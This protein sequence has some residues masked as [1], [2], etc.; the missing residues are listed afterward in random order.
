MKPN[1]CKSGILVLFLLVFFQG[2]RAQKTDFY[3]P[4]GNI[5]RKALELYRQGNY[6]AAGK[7]F[8]RYENRLPEKQNLK[9]E[10]AAYY[11]AD[12]AV[13]LHQ[14]DALVRLG[15][16]LSRY[17]E[18]VWLPSVKFAMGV[19]YFDNRRYSQALK[20]F[21]EVQPE[22]LNKTQRPEYDYKK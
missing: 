11:A 1:Y 3:E 13:K 2:L 14:S 22:K 16:F 10:N 9:A 4:P 17:P 5:Y 6:G 7:M 15:R 19:A 20:V 8:D 12:C 21:D 18:S